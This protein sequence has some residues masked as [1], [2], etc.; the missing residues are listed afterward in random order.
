MWTGNTRTEPEEIVS[1]AP[2][3]VAVAVSNDDVEAESMSVS[4][5]DLLL[6][7]FFGSA[8]LSHV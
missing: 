8:S 1:A 5:S 3:V 6:H 4:A 7:P 2:L